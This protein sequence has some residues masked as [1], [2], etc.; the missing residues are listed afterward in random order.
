[1][2]TLIIE[3][4][5]NTSNT[6]ANL[7]GISEV[8]NWEDLIDTANKEIKI[9]QAKKTIEQKTIV[10]HQSFKKI[11]NKPQQ[12]HLRK[13]QQTHVRQTKQTQPKTKQIYVKRIEPQENTTLILKNLPY[14]D[15]YTHELMDIFEKYGKL[16]YINVLRNEVKNCKGVAFIRFDT[17]EESDEALKKLPTFWYNNRKIFVEYAKPR[18]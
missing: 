8:E 7:F 18:Q 16:V 17:R 6:A 12:T 11:P 3:N 1:M 14:H 5:N 2:S 15:T 9:E 10:K 4:N 13:N